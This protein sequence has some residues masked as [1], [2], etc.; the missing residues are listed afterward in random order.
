[1]RTKHMAKAFFVI[2]AFLVWFPLSGFAEWKPY[3]NFDS[4]VIDPTKWIK[5]EGPLR[6]PISVENGA[7]KFVINT[8]SYDSGWLKILKSPEKVKGI[9][10]KVKI[11]SQIPGVRVRIGGYIAEDASGNPV[12][13]QIQLRTYQASPSSFYQV[14]YFSSSVFDKA[15]TNISIFDIFYGEF[16]K[17]LAGT[18]AAPVD[19]TDEWVT[20]EI[21]FDKEELN[22]GLPDE[23][24]YIKNYV[25]TEKFNKL[26][27]EEFIFKGIGVRST[28]AA[29]KDD[30]CI[31]Y[32][33]DVYV[34]Y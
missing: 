27:N 34:L 22:Y 20:M 6:D 31:V 23:K 3:D 24:N 7:A 33:D 25:I 29:P 2:C 15:N 12:F 19:L 26:T 17:P 4:G 11:S 32:F 1:M 16:Q 10:A 28:T 18:W 14:V 8:C 9:R 13:T 21:R 5:V 30:T